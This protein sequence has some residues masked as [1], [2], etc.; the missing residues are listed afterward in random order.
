MKFKKLIIASVIMV[1]LGVTA[2]AFHTGNPLFY[3]DL[4]TENFVIQNANL[5]ILGDGIDNNTP[6]ELEVSGDAKITG[7]LYL[8]ALQGLSPHA[9]LN[10]DTINNRT[11]I[12]VRA[13]DGVPVLMYLSKIGVTYQWIF[14]ANS[15]SCLD[16]NVTES[17]DVTV[18]PDGLL[19]KTWNTRRPFVP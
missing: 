12:C 5:E 14:V 1:V 4:D 15:P 13:G 9:F 18:G 19:N 2:Y 17:V 10:N 3:Y 16:K 11:E 8:G 7:I 6:Y